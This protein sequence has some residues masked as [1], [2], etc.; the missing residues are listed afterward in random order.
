MWVHVTFET[1]LSSKWDLP[2]WH[3]MHCGIWRWPVTGST[4]KGLCLLLFSLSSASCC[5][6]Q[7]RQT[8]CPLKT[9]LRSMRIFVA[10]EAVLKFKVGFSVTQVTSAAFLDRLLYRR[11]MAD[12]APST[13]TALCLPPAVFMSSLPPHDTSP[14]FL[15]SEEYPALQVKCQN[16]QEHR[17]H[18]NQEEYNC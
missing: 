6:W 3:W 12:M 2:L 13:G 14:V 17:G 18:C 8:P 4:V 16:K 1:V 10:A 15:F 11:R 9:Y 7:V 5:V